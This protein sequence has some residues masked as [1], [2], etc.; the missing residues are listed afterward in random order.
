MN[1]KIRIGSRDSVLAIRQAQILID[2]INANHPHMETELVLIKTTGD[3]L[4]DIRLDQVGGKGLFI[5][6]LEQALLA[7]RIDLAVHSYKDMPYEGNQELPIIAV[8]KR[9]SP[10]DVLVL[11]DRI[12][13]SLIQ[14][15]HGSD[16]SVTSP[17]SIQQLMQEVSDGGFSNAM[18]LAK[19]MQESLRFDGHGKPVGTCSHRR[20]LQFAHLCPD[21]KIGSIRGNVLTRL[22]KLDRGEYSALILAEAGLNRLAMQHRISYRFS[23]D[24]MIPAGSQGI[25]AVQGRRGEEYPYLS[26]FHCRD[27]KRISVGERGFLKSLAVGCSSPV[28]VYGRLSGQALDT[29][30]LTGMYVDANGRMHK[31]TIAGEAGQGEQLGEAL[32]R[33]IINQSVSS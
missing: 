4:L 27:T 21:V 29:L 20:A 33:E 1:R 26:G 12:Q 2:T 7:K 14:E 25:L 23:I 24:E 3:K 10:F 5:K 19:V 31:G 8:S 30:E 22:Q 13:Q 18:S 16:V 15:L 11:P 6:E 9:E 28:G 17:G 32:A